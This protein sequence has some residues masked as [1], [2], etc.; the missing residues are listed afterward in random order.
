MLDATNTDLAPFS[1]GGGKLILWHGE[2]DPA[3]SAAGTAAYYERVVAQSGGQDRADAFLR[4]YTAP[5]VHHCGGGP[6]AAAVDLVTPLDAWV[7]H[8]TA[9][10]KLVATHPPSGADASVL[11]RPLCTYPMYPSYNGAGDLNAAAS[12]TCKR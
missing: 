11:S 3:I 6:G 7:S 4:Y 10:A 9:P 1:A 8:A 5:A 12:F 2:A